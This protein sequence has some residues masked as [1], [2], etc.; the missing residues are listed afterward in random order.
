MRPFQNRI[1]GA[2]LLTGALFLS[3]CASVSSNAAPSS[4]QQQAVGDAERQAKFE[5]D[6]Q[7]ILAMA[8][9]YRVTFDFTETVA[10]VEDYDLKEP[11]VTGGDEIVR[12]IEDRGDFIS[13]QHILVVGEDE[14]FAIK[15][16]RQD[17]AYE[18]ESVLVFVGGNAW[19][20]RQLSPLEPRGKWTQTVYQVDDAPR[21]G[22]L[23][24]WSHDNGVSEWTPPA[25]WR[26]LPRRD[27]TKRDDYHAIDA[28]NRHAI[29]PNG[30][31]HEQD[32]T[33][34]VLTGAPH[35]LV[36]EVGVNTYMRSN[37]FDV[38]VAEDYW[39][40]TADYWAAVRAAWTRL[41]NENEAFGLTIQGEPEALYMQLLEL[42]GE[43][44][45]GTRET[46]EAAGKALRIIADYTT[47]D[48]GALAE[49]LNSGVKLPQN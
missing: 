41:E 26:P 29:T 24:R 25:E 18:P 23:G 13:L 33:K 36:R 11:Y 15:H 10:F 31:A 20:T 4:G 1:T 3:G 49:R 27:A 40:E 12:V 22:A 14:K 43:V 21:Y 37:D 17:W 9:D 47:S 45:D 39:A 34:L 16:W 44:N 28:V 48:I 30:W 7:A 6:R 5:Q 35:A 46:A 38:S 19:R 32:N 8:G 2:L 42:A